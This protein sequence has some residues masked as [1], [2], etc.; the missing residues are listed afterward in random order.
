V[1][2][3]FRVVRINDRAVTTRQLKNARLIQQPDNY[4]DEN[5]YHESPEESSPQL[6]TACVNK[7]HSHF[8]MNLA[9][10]RLPFK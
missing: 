6:F 1:S 5:Q 10:E 4:A 7:L 8:W 2:R 9:N 3:L